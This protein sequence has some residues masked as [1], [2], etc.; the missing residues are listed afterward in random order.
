MYGRVA[1]TMLIGQVGRGGHLLI[2]R[3]P[4]YGFEFAIKGKIHGR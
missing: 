2:H 1:S 4:A 3:Q